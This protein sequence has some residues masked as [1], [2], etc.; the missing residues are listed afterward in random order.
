M[1][2]RRE[3]GC[4]VSLGPEGCD[5]AAGLSFGMSKALTSL[6]ALCQSPWHPFQILFTWKTPGLPI[7]VE[8]MAQYVEAVLATVTQP[9]D[10]SW[11]RGAEILLVG[12]SSAG[13]TAV[14]AEM[15]QLWGVQ[16]DL[17]SRIFQGSSE[18]WARVSGHFTAFARKE[19]SAIGCSK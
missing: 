5:R 2:S 17:M 3:F 12:F 6:V 8:S 11:A 18:Y 1:I 16:L 14:C 19:S 13:K 9:S 7:L 10:R 15:T 4:D